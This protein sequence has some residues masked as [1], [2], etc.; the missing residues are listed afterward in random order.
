[1]ETKRKLL[2]TLKTAPIETHTLLKKSVYEI[3]VRLGEV[4]PNEFLD[5]PLSWLDI[6]NLPDGSVPFDD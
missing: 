5:E 3:C 2:L 4:I 1:M 6:I